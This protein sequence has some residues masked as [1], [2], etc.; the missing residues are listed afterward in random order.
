MKGGPVYQVKPKN[1]FRHP[2]NK[3]DLDKTTN[4]D[5]T[6]DDLT[7]YF[8]YGFNQDTMNIYAKLVK[9][10]IEVLDESIN[11]T[12][13][14]GQ[15]ELM[16]LNDEIPMDLGGFCKFFDTSIFVNPEGTDEQLE[17]MN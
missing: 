1:I 15:S 17:Y 5:T 13:F 2:F 9:R 8:N 11:P 10:T 14:D 4:R 3:F 12:Y 7:D 16:R 6:N